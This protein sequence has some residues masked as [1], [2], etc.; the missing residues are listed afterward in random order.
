MVLVG[1]LDS[2]ATR[3]TETECDYRFGHNHSASNDCPRTLARFHYTDCILQLAFPLNKRIL[4]LTR[5]NEWSSGSAFFFKEFKDTSNST[6][7]MKYSL[8]HEIQ[9]PP[10]LALHATCKALAPLRLLQVACCTSDSTRSSPEFRS[11]RAFAAFSNCTSET[12]SAPRFEKTRIC[13]IRITRS[14]A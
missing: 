8:K 5:L 6:R 7:A 9:I 10:L 14:P 13:E 3:G 1:D 12:L 4:Y 11:G 2:F